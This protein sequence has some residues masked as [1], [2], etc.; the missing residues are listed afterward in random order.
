MPLA[1]VRK[2]LAQAGMDVIGNKPEL[3]LRLMAHLVAQRDVSVPADATAPVPG[4]DSG[5]KLSNAALIK[6]ALA[7]GDDYLALLSLGGEPL[8]CES[9]VAALRRSYLRLSLRLHPDKNTGIE[10][11]PAAFQALVLA[12][13]RVSQKRLEQEQDVVGSSKGGPG[14][15]ATAARRE[16][17]DPD[18]PRSNEGCVQTRLL[19]PRCQM[20]WPR[21]E[22][23]LEDAAYTFMMVLLISTGGRGVRGACFVHSPMLL[24]PHP[25]SRWVSRSTPVAGAL[26]YSAAWLQCMS[27]RTAAAPLTT[28][29]Q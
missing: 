11:A 10:G 2:T 1:D 6:S 19:C 12:F 23:G 3:Q 17:V 28:V 20:D 14:V 25:H 18:A 7:C 21:K 16:R 26:A 15:N 5:A 29:G 13:E 8:S 24:L 22:L 4:A 9:P 27:A